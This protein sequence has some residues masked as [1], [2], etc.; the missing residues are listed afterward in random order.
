MTAECDSYLIA[1][2]NML[3]DNVDET[4]SDSDWSDCE[5]VY[6][7]GDMSA[8]SD[9]EEEDDSDTNVDDFAMHLIEEM[10]EVEVADI[11]DE[12]LS[13]IVSEIFDNPQS[14]VS[15]TCHTSSSASQLSMDISLTS[16]PS[17][18]FTVCPPNTQS[19]P[20]SPVCPP[21]TLSPVC[22]PVTLSPVRPL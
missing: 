11:V 1:G 10:V 4:D 8:I 6:S 3:A 20:N 17:T 7:V 14:S 9:A 5:S 2:S 19:L 16:C 13:V 18:Q 22:P 12:E 15:A 21:V